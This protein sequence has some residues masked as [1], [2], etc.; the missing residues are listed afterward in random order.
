METITAQELFDQVVLAVVKQGRASVT[1]Q[2]MCMYRGP[3]G[4]KCAVGHV[5]R[6]DE[7]QLD[8]EGFTVLGLPLPK[9]LKPH[10]GLL[11]ELQLAHDAHAHRQTFLS[12]FIRDARAVSEEHNLTMPE[13]PVT[14]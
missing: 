13:L 5:L 4:L 1:E 3:G 9:R 2:G 11:R 10:R 6:D 14:P 12:E 7:L 8:E